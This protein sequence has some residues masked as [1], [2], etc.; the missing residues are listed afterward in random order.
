MIDRQTLQVIRA[1]QYDLQQSMRDHKVLRP[2][3]LPLPVIMY[4]RA[5]RLRG[6]VAS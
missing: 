5:Q 4:H 6:G 1:R 2:A 3:D